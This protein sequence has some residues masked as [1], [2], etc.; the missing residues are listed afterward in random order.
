[1]IDQ[2]ADLMQPVPGGH[3]AGEDM[4]YSLVFD[5]IREARRHDDPSLSMGDWEVSL[6]VA[7]VDVVFNRFVPHMAIITIC[8]SIRKT[9][10]G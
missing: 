9:D 4:S 6:K 3:P 2:M 10:A 1:M 8:G 7:M 5:Q